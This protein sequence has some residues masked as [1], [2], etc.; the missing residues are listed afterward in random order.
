KEINEKDFIEVFDY[1]NNNFNYKNKSENFSKITD[2][3][4]RVKIEQEILSR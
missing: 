2:I 4:E 3:V 1:I